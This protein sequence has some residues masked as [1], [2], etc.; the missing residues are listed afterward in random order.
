M[1]IQLDKRGFVTFGRRVSSAASSTFS[2]RDAECPM[3]NRVGSSLSVVLWAQGMMHSTVLPIYCERPPGQFHLFPV[4]AAQRR[5]RMRCVFCFWSSRGN[6][7]HDQVMSESETRAA[8]ITAALV[9]LVMPLVYVIGLA[10]SMLLLQLTPWRDMR[11]VMFGFA[12]VWG[13]VVMAGVL[14]AARRLNR[15]SARV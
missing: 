11:E 14:V 8:F 5:Q 12:I 2:M 4:S 10:I 13:L 3:L 9:L 7:R 15:R 6:W 1:A